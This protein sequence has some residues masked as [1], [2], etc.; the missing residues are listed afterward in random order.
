MC[1]RDRAY[2][3][4]F[5][6]GSAFLS[7]VD[8]RRRAARSGLVPNAECE[9]LFLHE[10]NAL[11]V[12]IY[13]S[14]FIVIHSTHETIR[15]WGGTVKTLYWHD[16]E[17]WGEVPAKDRPSQFAG[18]RTDEDLNVIGAPLVTYCKPTDDVLPK[19]EACLVTG[20]TPQKALAEGLSEPEF[21]L[22]LI[23][24]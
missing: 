23:H 11:I 6:V 20:I 13:S 14:F 8:I 21:I 17:T 3:A 10:F 15:A 12:E 16:Y 7:G 4:R 18:I 5:L 1:I 19:P 22:S 2:L 24:I 9:P